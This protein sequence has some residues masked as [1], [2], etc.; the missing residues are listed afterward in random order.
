MTTV[1]KELSKKDYEFFLSASTTKNYMQSIEMY[2]RYKKN[3]REAYLLGLCEGEKIIIAGLV[4]VYYQRLG[5]KIFTMSRGPI[6]EPNQNLKKIFKFI[7]EAKSFI[8]SKGGICL[9]ISP[10]V[11]ASELPK[12]FKSEAKK[13]DL[14]YLG[15]Y[16]QVKWI[17]TINFSDIDKLPQKKVPENKRNYDL[18]KINLDEKSED[19]LFKQLH[20]NHRRAIKSAIKKY[21]LSLRELKIDEYGKLYEIIKESGDTQGFTPRQTSFYKEMKENFKEKVMAV[22]AELPDKTP[23]AVGFFISYGSDLIYLSGGMKRDYKKYGAPHLIQWTMIK[24][25]YANGFKKYNFWGTNPDPKNG[26]FRFKQGFSGKTE[27]FIGTFI[28]PITFLG[29]IYIKKIKTAEHRNLQ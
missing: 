26:V 5:K 23:I 25:A 8:K 28:T 13:N 3:G 2:D 20:N 17:Y 7:N 12:N 11:L 27:E 10:Y 9:Q 22:V 14:K 1:L 6:F 19:V 16:E 4:S 15:E 18:S 24:Y 21:N 29:K